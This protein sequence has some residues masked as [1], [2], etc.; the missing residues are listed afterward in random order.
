MAGYYAIFCIMS[1]IISMNGALF[2]KRYQ[3]AMGT[4]LFANSLYM[5]FNGGMTVLV[6]AIILAFSEQKLEMTPYSLIMAF[7]VAIMAAGGIIVQQKAFEKGPVAP[8]GV[9]SQMGVILL[10]CVWGLLFLNE[11]LS[12]LGACSVVIIIIAIFLITFNMDKGVSFNKSVIWYWIAV[13]FLSGFTTVFNK[14]HQVQEDYDKINTLSFSVWTGSFWIIIFGSMFL[15]MVT[16]KRRSLKNCPKSVFGIVGISTLISGSNYL[17]TLYVAVVLPVTITS[18]LR[19]GLEVL[20]CT[21]LPWLM[22][23]EKLTK[24]AI[25]G[26]VCSIVGIFLFAWS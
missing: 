13:F 23:K 1:L 11:T 8:A 6:P 4:D 17:V 12:L 5:I 14:V 22:Y 24:R 10:S 18:P 25:L 7:L 15:Y 26:V 19:A 20:L 2:M 21:L 16:F 9:C 3:V